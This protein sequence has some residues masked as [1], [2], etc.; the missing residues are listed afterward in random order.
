MFLSLSK[1]EKHRLIFIDYKELD[2]AL[3]RAR[4]I[5]ALGGIPWEIENEDGTK[6]E[7]H[8]IVEMLRNRAAELVGRP[9][10]Y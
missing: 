8:E 9:K 7:R 10:V 5:T 6:I 2:D 3:G 4:Q 1:A